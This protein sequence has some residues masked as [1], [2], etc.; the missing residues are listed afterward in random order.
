MSAKTNGK[1][2]TKGDKTTGTNGADTNGTAP[3]TG[4]EAI[5][6]LG[7]LAYKDNSIFGEHFTEDELCKLV[8]QMHKQATRNTAA[9]TVS[10]QLH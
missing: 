7:A 6:V 10:S 5:E 3:V 8:M 9:P 2:R 4:E 1:A